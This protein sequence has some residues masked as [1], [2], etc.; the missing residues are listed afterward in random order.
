[1][2][3]QPDSP[4]RAVEYLLELNNIIESQQK[5]L[6]QQ[7][8]RIDEL[9]RQLERLSRENRSL[10]RAGGEA[11]RS[12]A[13]AAVPAAPQPAG[14]PL[15]PDGASSPPATPQRSRADVET[16]KTI[17][18]INTLHQYC[19]YSTFHNTHLS[20]PARHTDCRAED[21]DDIHQ[22]CCPASECS[23]PSSR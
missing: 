9:E 21:E 23:S 6:E 17:R 7:R 15:P 8:R 12:P 20:H 4:S 2:E 5:L 13:S 1:M 22:F 18:S 19:C 10:R 14:G 16:S 11:E 3:G